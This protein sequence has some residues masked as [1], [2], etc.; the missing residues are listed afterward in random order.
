MAVEMK[1]MLTDDV[2]KW[3]QVHNEQEEPKQSTEY[4]L[5]I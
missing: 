2:T 5:Y 1:V 4:V 3:E